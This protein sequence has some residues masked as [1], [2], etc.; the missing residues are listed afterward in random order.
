MTVMTITGSSWFVGAR[1]RVHK[2][3][4]WELEPLV[5][6]LDWLEPGSRYEW[7]WGFVVD[8]GND[9]NDDNG[10]GNYNDDNDGNDGDDNNDDDDND[11]NDDDDDDNDVNDFN[12]G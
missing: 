5:H 7:R 3:H 8:N 2:W 10:D 9:D 1:S 4:H 6:W 12:D 11:D